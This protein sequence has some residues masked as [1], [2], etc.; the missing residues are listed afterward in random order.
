MLFKKSVMT[1]AV[2]AVGSFAVM[3]SANAAADN[4]V[5]SSFGMN[6]NVESVCTIVSAPGEVT[7]GNIGAGLATAALQTKTTILTLKCSEGAVPIISLSPTGDSIT[8]SGKMK[9]GGQE[10][11]YQLTKSALITDVWGSGESAYTL[12]AATKYAIPIET[13][14][15]A[16]VTDTADVKPGLYTDTVTVSVAY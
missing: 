4:P 7:I 9:F 11:N 10:V 6:V 12:A 13:T 14:I 1:A 15:Y 16:T 3:S 8:G 2:F 5:D